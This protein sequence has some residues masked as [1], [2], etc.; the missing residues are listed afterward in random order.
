MEL[1]GKWIWLEEEA[2]PDSYGE[3]YDEFEYHGEEAELLISADSNYAFYLNGVFVNSGQY[4]DYP[5]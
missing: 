1:N 4:P 3:F 5:H 2:T